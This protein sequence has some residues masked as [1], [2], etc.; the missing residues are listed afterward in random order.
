MARKAKPAE[1]KLETLRKL[2][3]DYVAS[4]R[5]LEDLG[6]DDLEYNI[7]ANTYM[8]GDDGH[9]LSVEEKF[10]LLGFPRKRVRGMNMTDQQWAAK[11]KALIKQYKDAGGKV[12]DLTKKDKIY[13]FL[14]Q[15]NLIVDGKTLN[16]EEKFKY[17]GEP[18]ARRRTNDVEKSLREDI[19]RYLASGGSFHVRRKSLPF[20]ERLHNYV[21]L[22]KFSSYEEAMKSL[23]YKNYS[24]TYFRFLDLQNIS[25]FCDE[26]G[27]FIYK[28]EKDNSNFHNI[29]QAAADTLQM[30]A[31]VIITLLCD[32]KLEKCVVETDYYEYLRSQLEQ[33]AKTN[34]GFVGIKRKAPQLYNKL[35]HFR[36]SAY[37]DMQD[38]L[39]TEAVLAFMGLD[40]FKFRY[41][42][43]GKS[44]YDISD[45]LKAIQEKSKGKVVTIGDFSN[46]LRKKVYRNAYRQGIQVKDYLGQ[47][48]IEYKGLD[49]SERF[50]HVKMNAYPYLDEMKERR[51]EIIAEMS[52]GKD[53][54]KEEVFEARVLACQQAY[55]EY[56]E[57]INNF[58]GE[59]VDVSGKN[60][61][62]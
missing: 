26:N 51:D 61:S 21:K 57:R 23:G 35:R 30:P 39:S 29:L 56:K 1:E 19:E 28:R 62:D 33:F 36:E 9:K 11:A 32:K 15:R 6:R 40:N 31:A 58:T 46:D 3:K 20:Y 45:E 55:E 12:D 8:A 52:E 59:K 60:L 41:W 25:K 4:G 13:G 18:R 53:L 54:C 37:N 17:L 27:F 22:R 10:S 43:S 47:F 2:L 14:A 50:R 24:D 42:E 5:K 16:M 7:I 38:E 44:G 34:N 48:G 49:A